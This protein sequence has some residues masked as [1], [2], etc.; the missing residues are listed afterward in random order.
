[1]PIDITCLQMRGGRESTYLAS[2]SN[3]AKARAY[4][5][6]AHKFHMHKVDGKHPPNTFC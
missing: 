5:G 2:D 4:I 1:M 3:K 6:M